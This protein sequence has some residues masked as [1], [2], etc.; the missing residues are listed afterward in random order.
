[1]ALFFPVTGD[2]MDCGKGAG[3]GFT[4][5][6]PLNVTGLGDREYL[7]VFRT[8]LLPILGEF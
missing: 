5:N 4:V 2:H 6:V 3:T 7:D 8:L 1:M